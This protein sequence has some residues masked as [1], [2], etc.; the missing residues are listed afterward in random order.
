MSNL[1]A[2]R[3]KEYED[4]EIRVHRICE[5]A[6]EED[7]LWYNKETRPNC[8]YSVGVDDEEITVWNFVKGGSR[9]FTRKDIDNPKFDIVEIFIRPE[10][11]RTPTSVREGGYP[12]FGGKYYNRWEWPMTNWMYT[13]LT[14]QLK[15]VDEENALE[16]VRN[17]QWIDVQPTMFGY[18]IQL[19]KSD[20]IYNVTHEEVL[21]EHFSPKWIIDHMLTA[22]Q[23]PPE[24]R[25]NQFE[26]R[27]FS[28]YVAIMLGMTH[29]P[30]QRVPI[31]K[32]GN[33]KHIIDPEG[34]S[35]I[36]R[37]TIH[38]RDKTRKLPK[39]IVIQVKINGEPI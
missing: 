39:P 19:D 21:D 28:N 20:L 10:P 13:R 12:V 35:V 4:L 15:F 34:V 17:E 9:T 25:G 26:D 38:V 18:S 30:G 22:R 37:T 33:K 6:W 2:D 31:K 16:G 3:I 23:V 11:N 7:P 1:I 27:R 29:L 24:L 36:E 14:G 32:C 8:K 5:K